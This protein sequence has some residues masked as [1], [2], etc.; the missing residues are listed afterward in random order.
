[1]LKCNGACKD[2]VYYS[3]FYGN[4]DVK[5]NLTASKA[6]CSA[7]NGSLKKCPKQCDLRVEKEKK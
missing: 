5:G 4:K 6:W 7:R 1:M 3:K 2:C